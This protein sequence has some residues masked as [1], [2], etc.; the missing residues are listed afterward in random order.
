MAARL[1]HDDHR[2]ARTRCDD[3]VEVRIVIESGDPRRIG[4]AR[5]GERD[6]AGERPEQQEYEGTGHSPPAA[7]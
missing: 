7:E 6:E 4:R 1:R 2:R 3:G 5:V